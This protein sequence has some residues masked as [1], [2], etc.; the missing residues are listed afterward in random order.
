[1]TDLEQRAMNALLGITVDTHSWNG[2]RARILYR[3]Y[4][5]DA[6]RPLLVSEA[7]DL[8]LL[9]WR[10]RRQVSHPDLVAHADAVVNGALPLRY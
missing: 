8:W 3:S 6:N 5:I 9:I 10:Y 2:R 4:L 1:M 7:G